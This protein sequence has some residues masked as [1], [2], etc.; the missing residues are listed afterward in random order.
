MEQIT[1]GSAGLPSYQNPSNPFA[2]R[3]TAATRIPMS[4]KN[5]KLAVTQIPGYYMAWIRSDRVEE[6]RNAG[7]VHVSKEEC[8]VTNSYPA[9]DVS[10]SGSTD[11]GSVVSV[12]ASSFAD[13][14]G[15][16]P[17]LFLMKLRIEWREMDEKKRLDSSNDLVDKLRG[18]T[19]VDVDP[20]SRYV[21]GRGGRE[22]RNM[23]S[24]GRKK[25][26]L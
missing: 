4:G 13:Q 14:D 24:L 23:F 12:A 7:Y 21:P 16:V 20:G 1:E 3:V 19:N 10:N 17:R 22:M 11:L 2:E 6:S 9:D 25:N 5:L 26:D 8:T 18:G 15:R